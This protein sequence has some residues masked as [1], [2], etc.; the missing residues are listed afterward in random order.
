MALYIMKLK[1][2]HKIIF[3]IIL[4]YIAACIT[5]YIKQESLLFPTNYAS[6]MVEPWKPKS[7]ISYEEMRIRSPKGLLY[8]LLWHAPNAR[9]TILYSHGNGEDI[10]DS[11]KF[12]PQ[13]IDRGYNVLIWDYRGYG[14]STGELGGQDSILADAESVYQ[15]LLTEKSSKNIVFYG[16]SLGSGFAVYLAHKHPGHKVLLEAAYDSLN[17]VAQDQYPIFPATLILKY[18]MPSV[19]WVK[20]ISTKIYMIHGTEDQVIQ[21]AHPKIL[22]KAAPNAILTMVKGIG[23]NGLSNTTTYNKWLAEAL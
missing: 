1:R 10:E 23:H 19:E 6:T 8:G 22:A 2:F 11:Q 7:H 15:W 5:L 21:A 14:L 20:N 18:Q 12:V 9:G 16:R 17:A 13:F 4:L 3:L